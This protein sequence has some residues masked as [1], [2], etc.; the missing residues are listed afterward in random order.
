[1]FGPEMWCSSSISP[2]SPSLRFKLM[3]YPN[4]AAPAFVRFFKLLKSLQLRIERFSSI[5][6]IQV[7]LVLLVEGLVQF[8]F[9]NLS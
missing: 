1:M 2:T 9:R 4:S 7:P 3:H 8:L 5:S 6:D